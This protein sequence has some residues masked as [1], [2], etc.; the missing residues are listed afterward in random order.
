M[1]SPLPGVASPLPGVAERPVIHS[2]RED[3]VLREWSVES[4]GDRVLENIVHFVLSRRGM[5]V[6][7]DGGVGV[8][9]KYRSTRRA[10]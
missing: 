10:W 1:A 5:E 2:Q 7:M 4:G 6:R 3:R 8:M 9:V